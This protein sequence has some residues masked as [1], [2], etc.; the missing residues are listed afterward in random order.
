MRTMTTMKTL[1]MAVGLAGVLT[2]PALAMRGT[3]RAAQEKRQMNPVESRLTVPFHGPPQIERVAMLL[4]PSAEAVDEAERIH[5]PYLAPHA[6]GEKSGELPH[7][8]EP[9]TLHPGGR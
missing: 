2:A 5:P 6:T 1:M 9:W 8:G 3:D 7:P 4:N